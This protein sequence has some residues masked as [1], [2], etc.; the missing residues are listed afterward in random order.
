MSLPAFKDFS[1]NLA[2]E[3]QRVYGGILGTNDPDRR[4]KKEVLS[5]PSSRNPPGLGLPSL[6][7]SEESHFFLIQTRVVIQSLFSQAWSNTSSCTPSKDFRTLFCFCRLGDRTQGLL[8]KQFG[9]EKTNIPSPCSFWG[10][11]SYCDV[12]RVSLCWITGSSS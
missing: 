8:Y 7:C 10:I 11:G 6:H 1:S 5:V 3:L 2:Q 9:T 12:A 4:D